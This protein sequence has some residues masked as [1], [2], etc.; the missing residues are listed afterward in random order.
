MSSE[1]RNGLS[2]S[3]AG[4][5]GYLK[6]K[7]KIQDKKME[8]ILNYNKNPKICL[9]C[10]KSIPYDK[11][12]NDF[13]S[14]SCSAS[15]H[16]QGLCRNQK[17]FRNEIHGDINNIKEKGYRKYE[18]IVLYCNNCGK[19]LKKTQKKYC[20]IKCQHDYEW[21]ITKEKIKNIG[22]IKINKINNSKIA[23]RFLKEENGVQCQICNIS[24]WMGKEVPL[25]LDHIDGNSDNWNLENLRLICGN[26][27]MQTPTY[28]GKSMGNGRHYRKERYRQGKSF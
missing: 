2:Q 18:E 3:E 27:D 1:K 15:Y 10:K 17:T 7:Q 22:H 11:R 14:R 21:R 12:Y 8:R 9:C 28:K 16:N 20:G 6:S 23:R 25:V 13:C 24:E 4:F 26:C 19:K 5:L